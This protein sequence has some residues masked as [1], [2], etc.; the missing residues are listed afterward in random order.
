MPEIENQNK[1]NKSLFGL[2]GIDS[3]R[4]ESLTDGVFAI[5]ITLLVVSLEVPSSFDQLL[6][7]MEGF[8]AFGVT[9]GALIGIWYIHYSFFKKYHLVDGH[10]IVLNSFLLFV[11]LFYIYP[12]KFLAII[13]INEGLLKTILGININVNLSIEASQWPQL[14]IIYGLG[15]LFI[16]LIFI[17]FYLHAYKKREELNLNELQIFS[18]KSSIQSF[19]IS[20][21][22]AFSS[23]LLVSIGGL[24][25]A[26]WSGWIYALIGPFNWMH[27][28]WSGKKMKKI[29]LEIAE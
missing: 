1:K 2:R 12:L 27:G 6:N 11:V 7:S 3:S 10:I 23:I 28:I 21:I 22:I 17:L 20:V 5:A 13:L 26:M 14:M 19:S 15:F 9:L 25:M 29:K 4:I 16:F 8:F 24:D 18:I